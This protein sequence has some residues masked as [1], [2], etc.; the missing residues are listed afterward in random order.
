MPTATDLDALSPPISALDCAA[1]RRVVFHDQVNSAWQH[2]FRRARFSNLDGL[3]PPDIP[4]ACHGS[5][6]QIIC[7]LL[8]GQCPLRVRSLVDL[9]QGLFDLL[10]DKT[11]RGCS[12][13]LDR[14]HRGQALVNN[15]ESNSCEELSAIQCSGLPVSEH[16]RARC[17]CD[18]VFLVEIPIGSSTAQTHSVGHASELPIGRALLNLSQRRPRHGALPRPPFAHG[19]LPAGDQLLQLHTVRALRSGC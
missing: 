13:L 14:I 17:M 1:L 6:S 19:F 18:V 11:A 2:T 15:P 16:H 10:L 5:Q 7:I 8:F 3:R 12:D 9:V 4:E